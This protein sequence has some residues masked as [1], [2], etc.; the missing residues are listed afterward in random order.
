MSSDIM[1]GKWKQLRGQ[2][3]EWWGELTDDDLDVIDGQWDKLVGTLQERYGWA[4]RDAE[5]EVSR[6]FRELEGD[7]RL[8]QPTTTR[9][10]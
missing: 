3:K 6:R 9:L 10:P 7:P 4:K 5:N 1:E 2:V 8:D